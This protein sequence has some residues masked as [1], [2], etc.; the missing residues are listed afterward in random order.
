[1]AYNKK[2]DTYHPHYHVLLVVTS[3]YFTYKNIK[4]SKW[5]KLWLQIAQLDYDSI[6]DVRAVKSRCRIEKGKEILVKK[7][8]I[9]LRIVSEISKCAVKSGDYL[10]KNNKNLT[11]EVVGT[12][13]S[14]L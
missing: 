4:K 2:E 14:F 9:E 3:S 11:D 7:R 8:Y 13:E 6:I 10:F 5:T 12:L 1:M